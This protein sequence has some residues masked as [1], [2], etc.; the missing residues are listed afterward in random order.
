MVR[1]INTFSLTHYSSSQAAAKKCVQF[2]REV[3][4]HTGRSMWNLLDDGLLK[5]FHT[6]IL[7]P[8]PM[9]HIF[10][11]PSWTS[12]NFELL[13][14][15]GA[16]PPTIESTDYEGTDVSDICLEMPGAREGVTSVGDLDQFHESILKNPHYV[17]H[18]DPNI[19]LRLISP[20]KLPSDLNL[21]PDFPLIHDFCC[22]G[23]CASCSHGESNGNIIFHIHGGGVSRFF[24]SNLT[25]LV[26]CYEFWWS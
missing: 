8:I 1:L 10:R 16:K 3:T 11:I 7:K 13:D 5:P 23:G 2:F 21:A 14:Y 17:N 9:S 20:F 19:K 18:L 12:G 26:C 6:M 25:H 4:P 24:I 22:C 15:M